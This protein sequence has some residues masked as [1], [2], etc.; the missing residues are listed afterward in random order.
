MSL[1]GPGRPGNQDRDAFRNCSRLPQRRGIKHAD[2]NA[3]GAHG[4]S[5]FRVVAATIFED[6]G[7]D[8][9][10]QPADLQLQNQVLVQSGD[11]YD[12]F[13]QAGRPVTPVLSNLTYTKEEVNRAR[14]AAAAAEAQEREAK[15]AKAQEARQMRTRLSIKRGPHLEPNQTNVTHTQLEDLLEVLEDFHEFEL[16]R[17][18]ASSQRVQQMES[19]PVVKE[20]VRSNAS[21]MPAPNAVSEG[22][23]SRSVFCRTRNGRK[24]S[25]GDQLPRNLSASPVRTHRPFDTLYRRLGGVLFGASAST[26]SSVRRKDEKKD[27]SWHSAPGDLG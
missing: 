3:H 13:E 20:A 17:P 12:I 24:E 9:V 21:L 27:R 22:W 6:M 2:R 8:F 15:D 18:T 25:G 1:Q 5:P 14:E 23:F 11:L 19:G 10:N 4:S 26:G 16:Q 7:K